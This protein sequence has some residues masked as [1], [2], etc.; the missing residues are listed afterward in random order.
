MRMRVQTGSTTLDGMMVWF[1][2]VE[3]PAVRL[4]SQVNAKSRIAFQ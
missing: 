3:V 2:P 4:S 1:W